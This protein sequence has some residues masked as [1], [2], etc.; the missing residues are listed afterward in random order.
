[1]TVPDTRAI[2]RVAL[3]ERYR[4]DGATAW[5]EATG[6]SMDPLIP[7][8][9]RLLVEFGRAPQR[10][11]EVI[12]FRRDSAVI[13][14]RFVARRGD[15]TSG[16]LVAKGDAEALPDRPI[17]SDDVLGVVRAIGTPDGRSVRATL[18][19][20][21]GAILARVS[22]WSGRAGRVAR[23]AAIHAPRPIRAAVVRGV[24]SLSRVPT[25]M[26]TA[27]MPRLDRGTSAGRR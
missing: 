17:A 20:R 18:G 14:H 19:G 10:P 26:I 27:T 5:I 23:R 22:W 21:S 9:S 25:R 13:A 1:M 16:R 24:L 15:A 4:A 11:G 7:A 2:A 3:F 6:A 8:G 12:V